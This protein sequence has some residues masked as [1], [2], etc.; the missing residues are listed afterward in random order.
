MISYADKRA[1]YAGLGPWVFSAGQ[2]NGANI[3]PTKESATMIA[4][5][6]NAPREAFRVLTTE[7]P[8]LLM[9]QALAADIAKRQ[10]E[11]NSGTSEGGSVSDAANEESGSEPHAFPRKDSD[12][13]GS[14]SSVTGGVT[15]AEI[16]ASEVLSFA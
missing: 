5:R 15:A 8:A 16:L 10:C 2:P 9:E 7:E 4:S 11:P 14:S 3:K 13:V 6:G 1:R 12:I